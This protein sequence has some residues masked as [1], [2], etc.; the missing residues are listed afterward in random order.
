ML[1]GGIV[2]P[3]GM[4]VVALSRKTRI[5]IIFIIVCMAY[6]VQF[7]LRAKDTIEEQ[8]YDNKDNDGAL[9]CKFLCQIAHSNDCV[10]YQWIE[11]ESK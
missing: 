11:K 4:M 1:A 3:V 8:P 9:Y 2:K 10:A 7:T 5:L 6:Q